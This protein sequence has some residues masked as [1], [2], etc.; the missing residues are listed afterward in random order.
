MFGILKGRS[1]NDITVYNAMPTALE[2]QHEP[3]CPWFLT[4]VTYPFSLQS[5]WSGRGARLAGDQ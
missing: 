1:S 4:R 2:A 3:H 5:T